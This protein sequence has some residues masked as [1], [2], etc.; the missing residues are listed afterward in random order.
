[1]LPRQEPP[2]PALTDEPVGVLVAV[3][4]AVVGEEE[5]VRGEGAFFRGDKALMVEIAAGGPH[6]PVE[7]EVEEEP[8]E[9]ATELRRI[10]LVTLG[11]DE[12]RP[13]VD[14][15]LVCS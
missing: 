4:V 5:R 9:I 15:Q 14:P 12:P 1:M 10:L 8:K 6:L 2:R 13:P 7:S 3:R 11:E